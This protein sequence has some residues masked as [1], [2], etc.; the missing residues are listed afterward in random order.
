M[1]ACGGEVRLFELPVGS[2]QLNAM[3]EAWRRAKLAIRDSEH[4]RSIGDMR[5]A[6]SEHFRRVCHRL[7]I[8]AYMGRAAVECCTMPSA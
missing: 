2:P 6:A 7:D 3:E 8:F 4:Y 1:R 5:A